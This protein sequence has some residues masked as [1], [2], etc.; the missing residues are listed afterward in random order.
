VPHSQR[1]QQQLQHTENN[2]YNQCCESGV[3]IPDPGSRIQKQQ[4]KRWVK[5]NLLPYLFFVAANMTKLKIILFLSRRR[6]NFGP[7]YKKLKKK[8]LSSQK[9]GFGI[10]DTRSGIQ[11]KNLF[12]IPEPG[13][14]GQKG[15]GSRIRIQNTAYNAPSS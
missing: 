9:Y 11:K 5:K 1:S 6:K 2:K 8:S 4:Q 3:F 14:R 7:I 15:T 13:S 10:R 12:R